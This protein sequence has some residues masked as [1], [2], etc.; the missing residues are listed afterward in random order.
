MILNILRDWSWIRK[1]QSA[2]RAL[3]DGYSDPFE[4]VGS[5]PLRLIKPSAKH[6]ELISTAH[7][8]RLYQFECIGCGHDSSNKTSLSN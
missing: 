5:K 8:A 6:V 4:L 7:L 1:N 3:L 2:L